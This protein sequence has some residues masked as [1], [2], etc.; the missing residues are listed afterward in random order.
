VF[1][2]G[3]QNFQALFPGSPLQHININVPHTPALHFQA[4]WFVQIDRVRSDKSRS[5]IVD[6]VFFFRSNNTE[7][8]P[9][10]ETRPIGGRTPQ[11][12][13]GETDAERVTNASILSSGVSGRPNFHT[14]RAHSGSHHRLGRFSATGEETDHAD[15][16]DRR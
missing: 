8:G 3:R 1:C 13:T 11:V 9:E 2:P 14:M 4:G 10:W 12:L 16:Q 15:S 7:T 5:V 6:D